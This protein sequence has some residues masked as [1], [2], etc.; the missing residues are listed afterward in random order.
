MAFSSIGLLA[1]DPIN[2]KHLADVTPNLLVSTYLILTFAELLL[3]P[4]GISFVSKVAP[5]QYK[6]M[7]MGGWFVAT[8]VGNLLVFIPTLIWGQELYIVWG[9]LMLICLL[10]ALFIFSI[11]KKLNR[12]A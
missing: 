9:V 1:P 3:S 2:P 7:M 11:I 5:P 12:V 6:G 8:A 4:I 10:A